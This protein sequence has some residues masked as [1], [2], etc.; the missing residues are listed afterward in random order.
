MDVLAVDEAAVAAEVGEVDRPPVV[1]ALDEEVFGAEA[2]EVL[3]L[4]ELARVED[5]VAVPQV[6]ADGV[7]RFDE[8]ATRV[9]G[10]DRL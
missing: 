8:H 10:I 7:G 6:S 2:G 9:D 4:A 3:V 5:H 1:R